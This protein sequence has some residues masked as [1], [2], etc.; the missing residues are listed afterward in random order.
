[1]CGNVVPRPKYYEV[2]GAVMILCEKCAKYGNPVSKSIIRRE[3][4]RR[5]IKRSPPPVLEWEVVSDY[6]RRIREARE[7]MGLTQE[8]LAR[9]IAEPVSYIRK[10]ETQKVF[11]SE[12]VI[13]KLEKVLNI[14]LR[15]NIDLEV[16]QVSNVSKSDDKEI[17]LALG[18]IL[19]VKKRKKKSSK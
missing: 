7:R 8:D 3:T 12:K 18:D 4:K 13:I 10:I 19:V 1:M 2:D 14:K 11:P 9:L 6:G 17:R 15:V 5:I 16:A